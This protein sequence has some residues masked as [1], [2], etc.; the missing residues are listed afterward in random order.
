MADERNFWIV[1][2][3]GAT[4]VAT[5][6]RPEARNALILECW[7]QLDAILL[8]AEEDETVRAVVL[9]GN[10]LAFSA[11]GDMKNAQGRGGGLFGEAYRIRH[12]HRV[13][14][15]LSSLALPT[16]AAVEGPAVGVGWGLALSCD[17]IVAGEAAR[18]IAP[19]MDRGVIPDGAVAYHLVRALGRLRAAEILL[20]AR[21]LAAQEALG[22][23][24]VSEVVE[25]GQALERAL[26]L[27]DGFAPRVRDTTTLTLREIRKAE[28][29]SYRSFLDAEYELISLNLHNPGIAKS[30]LSYKTSQNNKNPQ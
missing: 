23:G 19:F 6:D 15:R 20:K 13:L 3:K 5:L 12:L 27:A 21:P 29:L 25:R 22:Y 4:V 28:E 7:H 8:R 26:V 17:L 10:A 24:L 18:F 30:K 2:R 11:G 9:A 1:E 14:V 16:I